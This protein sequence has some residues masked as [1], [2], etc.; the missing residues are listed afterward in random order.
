MSSY[1]VLYADDDPL[2]LDAVE[3]SIGAD[4]VFILQSC[5]R[6]GQVLTMAAASP[7]DLLLCAVTLPDMTGPA[8][9]ERLRAH[10]NTAKIPVIFATGTAQSQDSGHLLSL[11]AVG[12]IAK[13]LDPA[14]LA[15]TM[16]K[17]LQSARLAAAGYDFAERLR[18][19]KATLETFRLNLRGQ[20]GILLAPDGLLSCAH[21]LAGAAGVFNL[22]AVS[23]SASAL[24]E[25][26]VASR[27]GR[28]A[29]DKIAA[30]L[31]ALLECIAR[32]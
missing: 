5:A 15:L 16:R 29:P 1:R 21:K 31:D 32:E 14:T 9:L 19:D 22:Q 3:Q 8:L 13:P 27:T 20:D 26:I 10:K 2:M 23:A 24:E 12:V 4:P 25:A 30:K 17:H 28:G 11:G 6:G 18:D 7:P